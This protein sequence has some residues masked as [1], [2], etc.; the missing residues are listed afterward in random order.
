MTITL[1][2]VTLNDHISWRGRWNEP[3]TPGSE[4]V[5]LGGLV[6]VQRDIAN[7]SSEIVLEAIEEDNVRK[8]YFTQP[9]LEGIRAYRDAGVAIVLSY[10]GESINVIVKNEGIRVEKV[11][12]KSAF[13]NLEKY[14]GSIT[15]M[16]V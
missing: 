7:D 13:D 10:H 12:W 9:Q 8:G 14:L 11:L 5:T 2:S 1:G 6:I 16:R 3:I 15:L 4:M